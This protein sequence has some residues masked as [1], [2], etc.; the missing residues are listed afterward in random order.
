MLKGEKG[1]LFVRP[2]PGDF[3]DKTVYGRLLA[4]KSRKYGR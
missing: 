2:E 4:G 3:A 1:G